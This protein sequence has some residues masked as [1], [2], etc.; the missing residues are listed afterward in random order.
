MSAPVVTVSVDQDI[1]GGGQPLFKTNIIRGVLGRSRM[2]DPTVS[3]VAETNDPA[4]FSKMIRPVVVTAFL[5]L[6]FF[7]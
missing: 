5:R 3:K 4:R 1:D 6:F 7:Q 2:W